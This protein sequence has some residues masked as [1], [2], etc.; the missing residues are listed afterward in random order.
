MLARQGDRMTLQ[1]LDAEQFRAQQLGIP[2][3][4]Q[5]I[6]RARRKSECFDIDA[7]LLTRTWGGQ[8]GTGLM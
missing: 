3:V 6:P 4:A 1:L 2:V 7:L 5:R 8:N